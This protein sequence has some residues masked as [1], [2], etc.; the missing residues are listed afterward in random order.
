MDSKR[1][2]IYSS[3]VLRQETKVTCIRYADDSSGV[4][5]DNAKSIDQ[6]IEESL[7]DLDLEQRKIKC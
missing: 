1:Q 3:N 7:Y 5:C 6:A 4:N 2:S